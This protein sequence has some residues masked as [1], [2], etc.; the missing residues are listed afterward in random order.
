MGDAS[1]FYI[2]LAI[3]NDIGKALKRTIKTLQNWEFL[4]SSS[5]LRTN[6]ILLAKK[7]SASPRIL[8]HCERG[9]RLNEP[10]AVRIGL[11][12]VHGSTV[13]H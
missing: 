6:I 11:F 4:N 13:A 5:V 9:S 8:T 12:L 1:I 2:R 3:T 10:Y 7:A